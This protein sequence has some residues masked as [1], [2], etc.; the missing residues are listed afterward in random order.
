M[1]KSAMGVIVKRSLSQGSA[2]I[3]NPLFADDKTI[4]LLGDGRE[5]VQG[6]VKVLKKE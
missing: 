3:P 5:M 2:G 6:I 4:M 1:D